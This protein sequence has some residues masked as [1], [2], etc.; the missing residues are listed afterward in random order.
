VTS[1]Q[2]VIP[3]KAGIQNNHQMPWIPAFAG[4]TNAGFGHLF[5]WTCTW[6]AA[7]A[8]DHGSLA[9]INLRQRARDLPSYQR[10]APS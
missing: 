5:V 4:M 6:D 7:F 9:G 8:A 2:S 1:F 3:A 10:R